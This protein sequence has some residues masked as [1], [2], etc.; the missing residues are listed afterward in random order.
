MKDLKNL[1]GT[2]A[3][4]TSE[5]TKRDIQEGVLSIVR[6]NPVDF[7]T[8][9][10]MLNMATN[11]KDHDTVVKLAEIV[12]SCTPAGES[13][14]EILS[15][16]CCEAETSE[17]ETTPFITNDNKVDDE[18]NDFRELGKKLKSVI[19]RQFDIAHGIKREQDYN[20][21]EHVHVHEHE[22][23]EI[24]LPFEVDVLKLE[25]LN[26][27]LLKNLEK[28]ENSIKTSVEY[29]DLAGYVRNVIAGLNLHKIYEIDDSIILHIVSHFK[30]SNGCLVPTEELMKSGKMIELRKTLT[31]LYVLYK[32]MD[33]CKDNKKA[34]SAILSSIDVVVN[35]LAQGGF[36]EVINYNKEWAI[37][38]DNF[39]V[40]MSASVFDDLTK[41]KDGKLKPTLRAVIKKNK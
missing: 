4:A 16:N 5:E 28:M 30:E 41:N 11:L 6:K 23:T 29:T 19:R 33:L 36:S 27:E 34:K 15:T 35:S 3:L 9:I 25:D 32:L 31:S 38:C 39:K 37:L 20:E 26:E 7:Q 18:M 22:D 2:V 17:E 13:I 14:E 1:L 40:V 12:D 24:V 10:D 8:A 21:D